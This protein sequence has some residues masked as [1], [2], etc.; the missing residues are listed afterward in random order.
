MRHYPSVSSTPLALCKDTHCESKARG[1]EY[2]VEEV[3]D[4]DEQS[5]HQAKQTQVLE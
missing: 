2:D 1:L 4:N 5:L 3:E